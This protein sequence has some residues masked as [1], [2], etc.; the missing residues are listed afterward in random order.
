M[1]TLVWGKMACSAF[2]V[3]VVGLESGIE[4]PREREAER[5]ESTSLGV[6][7]N[8][9]FKGWLDNGRNI[10]YRLRVEYRLCGARRWEAFAIFDKGFGSWRREGLSLR[11]CITGKSSRS[12]TSGKL[13]TAISSSFNTQGVGSH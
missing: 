5:L 12:I 10:E 1:E 7:G 13:A 8:W 9:P 3:E 11:C 4:W 6:S 2:R